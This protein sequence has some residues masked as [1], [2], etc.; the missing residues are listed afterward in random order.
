MKKYDRKYSILQCIGITALL[1][2]II[3]FPLWVEWYFG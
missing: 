3:V 1:I 2:F